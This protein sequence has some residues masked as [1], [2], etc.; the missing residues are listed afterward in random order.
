S[1]VVRQN[2]VC[3][4]FTADADAHNN[5]NLVALQNASHYGSRNVLRLTVT[6]R[7]KPMQVRFGFNLSDQFDDFLRHGVRPIGKISTAVKFLRHFFEAHGIRGTAF[8]EIST[9]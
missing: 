9:A 3:N 1:R 2:A 7:S 5:I 8:G 4:Y 6:E